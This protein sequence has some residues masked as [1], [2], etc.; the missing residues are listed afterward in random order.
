MERLKNHELIN[1]LIEDA[2]TLEDR[3]QYAYRRTI[4]AHEFLEKEAREKRE[5]DATR[6][7]TVTA[8]PSSGLSR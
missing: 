2:A 3:I 1:I 5:R 7:G 4:G 8:G 6:A